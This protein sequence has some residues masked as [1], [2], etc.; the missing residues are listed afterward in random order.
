MVVVSSRESEKERSAMRPAM[1]RCTRGG[2]C[3]NLVGQLLFGSQVAVV[4]VRVGESTPL[5]L[6]EHRNHFRVPRRDSNRH[7]RHR[8]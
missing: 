5:A 8:S 7:T 1:M 6:A 3:A 2:I 4:L